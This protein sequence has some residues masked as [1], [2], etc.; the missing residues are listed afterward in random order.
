[1][2]DLSVTD[3]VTQNNPGRTNR[4]DGA[5]P[6]FEQGKAGMVVG[7]G[8]LQSA[9]D[10]DYPSINYG[11]GPMPTGNGAAP[12]T[13]GVTDYLMS[14]KKEG[15]EDAVKAFYTL[16]YSPDEVNASIKAE[17]FLPVTLSGLTA[18][19]SDT[20]D[21]VYLDTLPNIHLVPTDDPEWD[22]IKL[23]I[24]QNIGLAVA[25]DGNP[26]CLC[27]LDPAEFLCGDSEGYRGSCLDR[28]LRA[29][30]RAFPYHA[31]AHASE[32]C[33]CRDIYVHFGVE[34]VC[35][36]VDPDAGRLEEAADRRNQF[37][38]DGVSAELVAT[39]RGLTHRDRACGHSVCNDR[40]ASGRG[41]GRWRAQIVSVRVACHVA[42]GLIA[43]D[44]KRV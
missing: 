29:H 6:L 30:A 22:K 35:C 43:G 14:F 37:L 41:H 32:N 7:F 19:A 24:Q 4:T 42:P 34:R 9:L 39:V 20:K 12:Q 23:T 25:P 36:G 3:N 40:E 44:G 13:F 21:K 15:N 16:Y 10:T 2:K 17:G 38:C 11:I 18:F 26:H 8:P 5:F 33:D 28:R 1:M 31:P 27:S